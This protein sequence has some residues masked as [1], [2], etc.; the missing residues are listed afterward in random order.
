MSMAA[1]VGN[2]QIL[3][4]QHRNHAHRVGFLTNRGVRCASKDPTFELL[5]DSFLKAT[6]PYHA[7]VKIKIGHH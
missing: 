5:K 7:T 4:S 6:N 1:M 2:D 3:G